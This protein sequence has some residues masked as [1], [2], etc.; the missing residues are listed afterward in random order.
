MLSKSAVEVEVMHPWPEWIEL[1][2]RMVQVM[3]FDYFEVSPARVWISGTPNFKIVH[4]A[5]LKDR[6]DIFGFVIGM[7]M[8]LLCKNGLLLY[9]VQCECFGLFSMIEI[10]V[11]GIL[12]CELYSCCKCLC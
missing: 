1:M 8:L 5:C 7:E 3:G 6:F 12:N 4:V 2:E 9:L 10:W 11:C